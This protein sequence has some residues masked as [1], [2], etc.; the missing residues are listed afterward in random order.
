MKGR[1]KRWLTF[2]ILG[3]QYLLAYFQRVCPAV[4]AQELMETFKISATSMGMLSSTY[5]YT[6]GL[7]QVPCGFLN[8]SWGPK[9]TLTLF[10]IIAAI[11]TI[12]FGLSDS[13]EMAIV[14][15]TL[16][17]L[18][19]S[20]VFVT[21]MKILTEYFLPT[22]IGRVSGVLMTLGGLGW[23]L[24]TFPLAYILEE[25]GFRTTFVL[26]GVIILSLTLLTFLIIEDFTQKRER[27]ESQSL[28]SLFSDLKMILRDRHF[29]GIAFWFF[30]R[31]GALFGFFGLWAG[32]YLMETY[33]FT[34]VDSGNI[35][36]MIA[37][38]MVTMGPVMGHISDKI[39]KSRKK[40]LV[41]TSILNSLSWL[42]LLTF[43]KKLD[44]FSLFL[45]F[46]IMGTTVSSVGTI[47]VISI[48]ERFPSE[49]SGVSMGTINMFPFLGGVV[50]QPLLGYIVDISKN[51][52]RT[53]FGPY[54][55]V[56][57]VLFIGSLLALLSVS[58]CE[59]TFK[60]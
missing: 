42:T 44:A 4:L 20:V 52:G 38:A 47:A 19:V 58:L 1:K 22:E 23:F 31:G 3:I 30:I 45:I 48:R 11:S 2:W 43:S 29:I 41:Y 55:W 32:P 35:L 57:L 13:F 27:S 54:E 34:V 25:I 14:F 8:D 5:F 50:F 46:F 39:L 53:P 49:I 12:M 26:L 37:F 40:V 16:V 21:S 59:E 60:D 18:G 10:G 36:S 9:K 15:R 7:M 56:I 28:R 33:S 17:G 51:F 24:A 6:Y